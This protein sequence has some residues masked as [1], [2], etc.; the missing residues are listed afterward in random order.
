[1]DLWNRYRHNLL[2][3]GD[4]HKHNKF[5]PFHIDTINFMEMIGFELD[6]I[7]IWDRKSEYNN[8][9]PSADNE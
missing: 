4:I 1:M 9:R 6:D 5:Y 2:D 8:L 7:I 3:L